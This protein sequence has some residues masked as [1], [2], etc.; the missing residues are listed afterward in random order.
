MA[1]LG[2]TLSTVNYIRPTSVVSEQIQN[3]SSATI[4]AATTFI[5]SGTLT[6]AAG[7]RC[8]FFYFITTDTDGIDVCECD[9]LADATEP[10]IGF[11]FLK[12]GVADQYRTQVTNANASTSRDM[13]YLTYEI[14]V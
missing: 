11:G 8:C 2:A 6:R 3:A 12:S 10:E 5:L 13:T 14:E 9:V 4:A 1:T 7:G